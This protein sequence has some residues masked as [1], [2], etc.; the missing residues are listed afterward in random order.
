MKGLTPRQ[1]EILLFIQQFIDRY[2]YSPSYR[3][4]MKQFSLASPGSVYKHIRTLQRKGLLT[5]ERQCSRSIMPTSFS[6][7]SKPKIEIELPLIGNISAG[8]PIEIFIQS[9]MLAVPAFLVHNPENT[10]LLKAQG[11]SLQDELIQDG[12]LLLIEARSDIQAGET[13]LGLINQQD[14]IIKKYY[15]EGQYIRL[16][17]HLP[18]H[19]SLTLRPDQ[20]VIQGVLIGLIRAY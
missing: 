5:A 14:S 10:Y 12:D 2:H 1:Q 9:Q 8:Y 7:S 17:S 11:D 16:E 20:M 6:T 4:I 15:P 19:Q 13:I 18:H 3:E